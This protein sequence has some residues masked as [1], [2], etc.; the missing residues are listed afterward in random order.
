MRL[1]T[2]A[3]IALSIFVAATGCS[4]KS[5]PAASPSPTATALTLEQAKTLAAAAV[6]TK[7]DLPGYTLKA[8]THDP[9][10][11][12]NDSKLATCLGTPT[13]TY[14][15]RNFGTGFTKGT[16]EIDSSGDVASSVDAAK[17]QLAALTSAKAPDCLKTLFTQLLSASGGTI[18]KFNATLVPI[19]VPQS[20]ASFAYTF[21]ITASS[22]GQ[23]AVLNGIEAGSLVGQ[24]EVDVTVLAE[25]SSTFTLDQAVALLR[26][27]S[28]RVQAAS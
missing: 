2:S 1:R 15:T 9:S 16:L 4:A 11:D 26:T 18:S 23:S 14:L 7:A 25:G 12:V 28:A 6:L 17:T 24:V 27:A 19:T 20:D 22:G 10:D 3:L 8:Q 5:H 13:P 21:S